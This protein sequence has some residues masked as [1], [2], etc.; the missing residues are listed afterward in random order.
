[1]SLSHV[2]NYGQLFLKL[3]TLMFENKEFMQQIKNKHASTIQMLVQNYLEKENKTLNVY[4]YSELINDIDAF[5]GCIRRMATIDEKFKSIPKK[6][7]PPTIQAF[8]DLIESDGIHEVKYTGISY[9]YKFDYILQLICKTRYPKN[10]KL[11]LILIPTDTK[12]ID[13][14]DSNVINVSI[15]NQYKDKLLQFDKQTKYYIFNSL[16]NDSQYKSKT[17][18]EALRKVISL[19]QS[20]NIKK[21]Y[22]HNISDTEYETLEH[23]FSMLYIRILTISDLL[24]YPLD[25]EFICSYLDL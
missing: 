6:S 17:T 24:K 11:E 22:T 13:E 12:T 14:H 20:G 18:D 21:T 16:I 25:E 5:D 3:K 15:F 19:A 2:Y 8:I 1:M 4:M 23:N 9:I 7:E 10:T